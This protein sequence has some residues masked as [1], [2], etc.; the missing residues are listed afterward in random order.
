M[1]ALKNYDFSFF[2]ESTD[3]HIAAVA[4]KKIFSQLKYPVVPIDIYQ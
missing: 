4:I 2:T 3:P 1:R